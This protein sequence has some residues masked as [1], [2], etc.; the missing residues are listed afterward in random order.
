MVM[1]LYPP[2]WRQVPGYREMLPAWVAA[3]SDRWPAVADLIVRTALRVALPALRSD[4]SPGRAAVSVGAMPVPAM[5]V[6][7]PDWMGRGFR[8]QQPQAPVCRAIAAATRRGFAR[9]P[10][11]RPEARADER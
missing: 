10:L 4:H 6:L 2:C 9:H 8:P 3:R 1:G 11:R 5:P 7:P